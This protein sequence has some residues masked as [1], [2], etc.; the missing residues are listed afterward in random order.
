V[1]PV[2]SLADRLLARWRRRDLVFLA[3]RFGTDK[4]G[5]HWYAQHYQRHFESFR[6]RA[7]TLLE[8][9]VGGY[10]DPRAGGESLRMWK[11]YFPK[12]R[13]FGLDLY[14]K[15][16]LQEERI[17]IF[18]GS[19]DDPA[20]LDRVVA[21][22]GP[23]DVVIDDGSHQNAHVRRTFELL[24]PHVREGGL[25]A[26]EDLQTSYWPKF[27]GSLDPD[28][29]GTSMAVFKRLA[30]GL[31]HAERIAPGY[32]PTFLDRNVKA[33]HF[34]HNLVFV[35]RGPN[36]EGSNILRDNVAPDWIVE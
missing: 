11:A 32:Q 33:V 27:G 10:D 5:R 4:W 16:A 14:D 31:N 15:S 17:R 20:A 30:D 36:D 35:E 24:F 12:A 8:I 21:E 34:Y 6:R 7:I 18:Q 2:P 9:G 25:Y 22:T 3:R 13:I 1:R 23:L 19:Q 26:A 28:A 29:D